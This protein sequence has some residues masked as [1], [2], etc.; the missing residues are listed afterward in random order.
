MHCT[1]AT[2]GIASSA[3]RIRSSTRNES[4]SLGRATSMP[5]CMIGRSVSML[6]RPMR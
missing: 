3:F 1:R 2:P 5:N 4:S 6:N